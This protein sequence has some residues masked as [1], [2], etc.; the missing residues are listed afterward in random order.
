MESATVDVKQPGIGGVPLE[1]YRLAFERHPHPMWVFDVDT[2]AFIDV[3]AA[4]IAHYGYSREEFMAMTVSDIHQLDELRPVDRRRAA[5][6]HA[7][8][9]AGVWRHR[10]R[11]G[12][13]ID[14]E[15]SSQEL[16]FAGRHARVVLANDVTE[17][18]RAESA[19]RAQLAV[20]RS[21]AEA[22]SVE[23]ASASVLEALGTTL[24]WDAAE[25]WTLDPGASV[26][27]LQASWSRPAGGRTTD[28]AAPARR[29]S[30]LHRAA[31]VPVLS[32]EDRLGVLEFFVLAPRDVDDAL[33]ETL[34]IASAQLGQFL[35]RKQAEQELAHQ[36]LHDPLTGLPNR[37]L[38]LDRLEVAL[39]HSRRHGTSVAVLFL[40]IDNFKL[41]NDGLGHRAGDELL[42]SVADRIRHVLGPADSVA[43]FGGDE[44]VVIA[45]QIERAQDAIALAQRINSVFGNSFLL[46]G[47]EQ[48]VSTS[49]GIALTSGSAQQAEDLLRDADA[50]MYRAKARGRGRYEVFDEVM[51]ARMLGRLRTENDLRAALRSDE[52]G[53]FYQ[54]IVELDSGGVE[55]V[56]ALVRWEHPE[57]GLLVP[58]DFISVAEDSGLIVPVGKWVLTEACRRA[59][60]WQR[61]RGNRPLFVSV[62]V[63]PTQVTRG[64]L[65]DDVAAAL[66]ESGLEP[67]LLK[68]ELTEKALIEDPDSLG[69]TLEQLK[70]LGV[71]LVLDDF[72]TGYSALGYLS[73]FPIDALKLDRSFVGRIGA[74]PRHSAIVQA[75]LDMAR[76]LGIAVVAKGVETSAQAER[77]RRMGCEYAQGF[78]FS[79]ATAGEDLR[80]LLSVGGLPFSD[81]HIEDAVLPEPAP[82]RRRWARVFSRPLVSSTTQPT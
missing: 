35:T 58:G 59:A 82:A 25:L 40:D 75:V 31:A 78:Y 39:A 33:L 28:G 50:A 44:F 9:S 22:S 18:Q 69:E 54:P 21:L 13:L 60:A 20:A 15:L 38:L 11:S 79:A 57:R 63:S 47:G 53:V 19:Q 30:D 6:Q 46:E 34:T 29:R 68:L 7:N 66:A 10:T 1:Q 65:V 77:L 16:T 56:E 24:S 48:V 64:S 49:I 51:H 37:T 5:H 14:V 26:L 70:A 71:S 4:A 81:A 74:G 80:A 8:G 32:G 67:S 43:R 12:S 36:A 41:I 17:R 76:A 3:N 73:R 61:T 23:D 52:L 45:D 72:G 42:C 62:N 55:G 2:L 27:R